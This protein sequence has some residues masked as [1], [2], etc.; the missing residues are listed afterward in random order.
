MATVMTAP[1][2]CRRPLCY[3]RRARLAQVA[4]LVFVWVV[5]QAAGAN[6]TRRSLETVS[7]TN[8]SSDFVALYLE[9]YRQEQQNASTTASSLTSPSLEPVAFKQPVP[10][11]IKN[12]LDPYALPFNELPELLK[13]ALLWESGYSLGDDASLA[14]IHTLCGL[15]MADI[16]LSEAEFAASSCSTDTCNPTADRSTTTSLIDRAGAWRYGT[17]CRADQ[18]LS[19]AKCAS[20]AVDTVSSAPLWSSASLLSANASFPAVQVR[21]HK[22]GASETNGS[23]PAHVYAI[24]G[25]VPPAGTAAC[26]LSLSLAAVA[27]PCVPYQRTDPRWCRPTRSDAMTT[28]LEEYSVTHHGATPAATTSLQGLDVKNSTLAAAAEHVKDEHGVYARAAFQFDGSSSDFAEQLYRRHKAG[29]GDNGAV[30]KVV[31]GDR[32]PTEV[33]GRLADAALQFDDLPA[34][35]QQALLWDSGFVRTDSATGNPTALTAVLVRCGLSMGDIAIPIDSAEQLKGSCVLQ[36]CSFAA[37]TED[38]N[39]SSDHGFHR[40]LGCT[41]DRLASKSR[42]AVAASSPPASDSGSASSSPSALVLPMWAD[43]GA[44]AAIPELSLVRRAWENEG[45]FYE[46]FAIHTSDTSVDPAKG[47]SCPGK[48]SMVIPCATYKPSA[49]SSGASGASRSQTWCRPRPG[50]LVS[51]W[52]RQVAKRKQYSLLY[53]VPILVSVALT[54]TGLGLYIRRKTFRR[55]DHKIDGVGSARTNTIASTPGGMYAAGSAP[56]SPR[57]TAVAVDTRFSTLSSSPS[58]IESFA[59]FS[60]NHVL[61]TLVNHPLLRL[62]TVPYD[63]IQFLNLLSKRGA[64]A[65]MWLA[66][67]RGAHVALKRLTR[68]RKAEYDELDECMNTDADLRPLEILQHVAAGELKPSASPFCPLEIAELIDACLN[69]DPDRRPSASEVVAR[70]AQVPVV[71]VGAKTYSF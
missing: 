67:V 70:L 39:S 54:L 50:V 33:E 31:L 51:S 60:S 5:A 62:H 63:Q 41:D 6:S 66:T 10:A 55:Y 58:S 37:P 57:H 25:V 23:Q 17:S 59:A 35:L 46:M 45:R 47:T 24:H 71:T 43:G 65:E 38:K 1:A 61:N 18:L 15:S 20:T 28:W 7:A 56:R 21:R 19:V 22:I 4:M 13:R 14:Q 30:R 11:E 26:T 69:I 44:D 42:C 53:L 12:R 40:L 29:D 36:N 34:L 68:A 9:R 27:I 48:P 8:G 52:L 64:R 2:C 32:L 16:A 49:G 3:G